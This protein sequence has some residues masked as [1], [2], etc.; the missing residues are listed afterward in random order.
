MLYLIAWPWVTGVLLLLLISLWPHRSEWPRTY[1]ALAWIMI[2]GSIPSV[3]YWASEWRDTRQVSVEVDFWDSVS[4]AVNSGDANEANRLLGTRKDGWRNYVERS[5]GDENETSSTEL[6]SAAFRQCVDLLDYRTDSISILLDEAIEKGHL[7]IV[8]TWLDTP[9]CAKS[10]ETREEGISS[11]LNLL[12]PYAFD[13][14]NA[15]KRQTERRQAQTLR[16]LVERYPALA[17]VPLSDR[18]DKKPPVGRDCPTL[19]MALLDKWHQ[20]GIEAVLPL[21]AHAAQ[22]LPPVVLHV[23]RGEDQA[24]AQSAKNDP[25][26]FHQ[27]LPS[28]MAT[29]PLNSLRAAL[30]VAPPD[31]T[32]LLTPKNGDSLYQHLSPLF[33]AAERRDSDDPRWSFLW[34]MFELFPTR[35][36]DVD[37]YLYSGYVGGTHP[38][39][40][41]LDHLMTVLR[42]AGLS[43]DGFS[44]LA[45]S[46]NSSDTDQEWQW[47]REKSGCAL[48]RYSWDQDPNI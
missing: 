10:T 6:L 4:S 44:H 17:D 22:H 19:V 5:V 47:Y 29:A 36:R 20:E 28:L 9:P 32:A 2:V 43:C 3:F 12:V 41:N 34:T 8:K 18:C 24:A 40:V 7:E 25:E 11:I 45:A 23:L 30:R 42:S 46:G 27:Y 33:S 26:V 35:L 16:L 21:D 31:E 1:L 13:K 38:G 14:A 48:K 39:D 15:A 37:T